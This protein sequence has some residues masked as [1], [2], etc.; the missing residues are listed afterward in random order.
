M[1]KKILCVVLL[2]GISFFAENTGSFSFLTA[3]AGARALAMG[4][5]FTALADDT[6]AL[7]W[8]PAGLVRLDIYKTHFTGMFCNMD[9]GRINGFAGIYEKME[10]GAGSAGLSLYYF[11][12][13]GIEGRDAFGILAGE[14]EYN[15]G[16]LSVSYANIIIEGLR[17]G[18]NLKYYYASSAEST[19][20][21]FGGDL[22][23]IIKPFGPYFSLGLAV[24][25]INTGVAWSGGRTD[26]VT[27]TYALG[28][29]QSIIHEKFF[30]SADIEGSAFLN[31]K[32]RVGSEY[33][34]SE[35]FALRIGLNNRDFT[36]GFG[37]TYQNYKIDYAFLMDNDGFADLHRF[38]FSAGF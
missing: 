24:K 30:V 31:Y 4:G 26:Y 13:G 10:N 27:T 5:A 28:A 17:C 6:S 38:S 2:A 23:A 21:G 33:C 37:V 14:L 29:A 34:I 1:L 7:Y 35:N 20:K 25:D 18:V 3:G 32:Y 9:Y 19:G 12:V 22:G 16:V 11:R 36:S 15:A 8:N